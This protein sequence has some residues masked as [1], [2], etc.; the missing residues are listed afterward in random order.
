MRRRIPL[1][2]IQ[3][4]PALLGNAPANNVALLHVL[5]HA[6]N[7]AGS[8]LT[9][10]RTGGEDRSTEVDNGRYVRDMIVQI[11]FIPNVNTVGY[12]EIAFI[13]Y[14]RSTSV[15]TIGTDPVPTSAVCISDGLQGAIRSLSPGYMIKFM[16]VPVTKETSK[17]LSLKINWS[18]Y[19][20]AKVRDGDYFCLVV[21]NKSSSSGVYDISTRYNTSSN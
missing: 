19:R 13:K 1:N 3:H 2:V 4:S 16:Q 8:S 12:Y 11:A 7:L 14:E 20:K 15:P 6:G 18:K 9:T 17:V 10:G 21:F 5:A